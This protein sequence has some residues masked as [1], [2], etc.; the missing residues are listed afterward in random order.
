MEKKK[1]EDLCRKLRATYQEFGGIPMDA[2]MV[3]PEL[4]DHVS[5]LRYFTCPTISVETLGG[6]PFEMARFFEDI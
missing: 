6:V 4:V 1:I 2:F 5:T 3:G